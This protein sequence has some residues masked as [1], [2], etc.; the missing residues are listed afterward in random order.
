[1]D[2]LFWMG[3]CQFHYSYL[4]LV[5]WT[6]RKYGAD[7]KQLDKWK[8]KD[9]DGKRK[10]KEEAS[11]LFKGYWRRCIEDEEYVALKKQWQKE[12]KDFNKS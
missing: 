6:C 2:V 4:I 5:F 10:E 11:E 12:K 3:R 8:D 7:G 9:V 1:M